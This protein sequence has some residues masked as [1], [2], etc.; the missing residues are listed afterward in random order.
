MNIA[1]QELKLKSQTIIARRVFDSVPKQKGWSVHEIMGDI[2]RQGSGLSLSVLEGCLHSLHKDG[3]IRR[4]GDYWIRVIP[5]TPSP[6][7]Q[8][9]IESITP[10]ED[11]MPVKNTKPKTVKTAKAE[12][13]GA[14]RSPLD[15]LAAI[16]DQAK[17]LQAA[18]EHAAIEITEYVEA[19][20]AKNEKLNQLQLILKSLA[21]DVI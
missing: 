5:S 15:I 4:M 10:K 14:I 7:E 6:H 13:A 19:T 3:L 12:E 18:V 16:S 1:K 2:R 8:V 21:G 11:A 20:E 9:E 17:E